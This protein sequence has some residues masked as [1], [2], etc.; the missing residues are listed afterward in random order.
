MEWNT[1]IN[2]TILLLIS[3]FGITVVLLNKLSVHHKKRKNKCQIQG[4]TT[5]GNM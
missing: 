4:R 2:T 1:M 5:I 3:S